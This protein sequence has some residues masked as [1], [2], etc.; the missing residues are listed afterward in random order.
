MLPSQT[1]DGTRCTIASVV[2]HTGRV[3]ALLGNCELWKKVQ[4]LSHCALVAA[5]WT[6]FPNTRDILPW[7]YQLPVEANITSTEVLASD[8]SP[9][10]A[11]VAVASIGTSV[12]I[13][14]LALQL[15]LVSVGQVDGQTPTETLGAS[16]QG[17]CDF[18]Q[19]LVDMCP[20]LLSLP[21]VPRLCPPYTS[22]ATACTVSHSGI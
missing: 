6:R 21:Q 1:L 19:S 2:K 8:I 7:C 3:Q 20:R 22:N 5:S 13:S 10:N 16:L 11:G 15:D 9:L 12:I 14:S 17:V 18:H 4:I